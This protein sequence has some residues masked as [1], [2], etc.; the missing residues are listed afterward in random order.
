MVYGVYSVSRFSAEKRGLPKGTLETG[1][2]FGEDEKHQRP[3]CRGRDPGCSD[4]KVAG[5]LL[6][7]SFSSLRLASGTKRHQRFL[8]AFFSRR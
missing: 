3:A 6:V 2:F 1:L 4:R 5:A 7:D 8:E